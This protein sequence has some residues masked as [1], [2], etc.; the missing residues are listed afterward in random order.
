MRTHGTGDVWGPVRYNCGD[1]REPERYMYCAD[2]REAVEEG[3]VCPDCGSSNVQ[4]LTPALAMSIEE[5]RLDIW[6]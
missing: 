6:E 3:E 2:C 5:D 1:P 4:E